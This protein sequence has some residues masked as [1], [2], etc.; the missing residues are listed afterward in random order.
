MNLLP[1]QR[2]DNTKK[3]TLREIGGLLLILVPLIVASRSFAGDVVGSGLRSGTVIETD[4]KVIVKGAT[5]VVNRKNKSPVIK[6]DKSTKKKIVLSNVR[7]ISDN[8]SITDTTGNAGIVA[9]D[10]SKSRSK[11]TM[12][13]V[14][15]KARNSRITST[16]MKDEVCAGVICDIKGKRD[17]ST[18]VGVVS[19]GTTTVTAAQG[20]RPDYRKIPKH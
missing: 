17:T 15:V 9:I 14:T 11:V 3:S 7:I 4:D 18:S 2:K 19:S 1:R 8:Q 12:R 16:S 20:E 6:V 10:N 5:F 13:N